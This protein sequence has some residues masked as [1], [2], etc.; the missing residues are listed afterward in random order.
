MKNHYQTWKEKK[1]PVTSTCLVIFN[2][3][4]YWIQKELD[5]IFLI[6]TFSININYFNCSKDN[7]M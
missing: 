5:V 6:L 2:V 4:K 7:Y 3:V 1:H